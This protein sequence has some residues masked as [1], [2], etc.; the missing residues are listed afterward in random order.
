M[1]RGV[2]PKVP[3]EC[4]IKSAKNAQLTGVTADK[5]TR[6]IKNEKYI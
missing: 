1:L 2:K 6:A 3:K 5:L 4:I